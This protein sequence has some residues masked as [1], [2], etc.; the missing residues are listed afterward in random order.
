MV[1]ENRKACRITGENSSYTEL[2][3]N[4]LKVENEIIKYV[5][6]HELYE[7]KVDINRFQVRIAYQTIKDNNEGIITY[8]SNNDSPKNLDEKLYRRR[9]FNE[10][11]EVFD[12]S[13]KPLLL[14]EALERNLIRKNHGIFAN[15][16]LDKK[17]CYSCNIEPVDEIITWI[18]HLARKGLI[19][20]N[21]TAEH[22]TLISTIGI[23]PNNFEKYLK[24]LKLT[25]NAFEYLK[26]M[27]KGIDN[28]KVF[29]AM[30]FNL[31]EKENIKDSIRNCLL[32]KYDAS[33]VADTKHT[34]YI[35][36]KIMV[37]IK[38]CKF[39]VA[40]FSNPNNAGVYFEAGYARGL[41]KHVIHVVPKNKLKEL[42]FDTLQIIHIAYSNYED[43]K[44]QLRTKVD[45]LFK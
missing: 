16:V 4:V 45:F 5:I 37:G 41:G 11:D 23:T 20:S 19:E 9:K 24:N 38:N 6:D 28:N 13:Q 29:I 31:P 12:H 15:I 40:D 32:P 44:D 34:E 1:I 17:T 2:P 42:H 27:N 26:S 3:F 14:L 33:T 22:E 21:Y 18:R 30:D 8:W 25:P 39:M 43:L 7:S 10:I 36:E 35:T